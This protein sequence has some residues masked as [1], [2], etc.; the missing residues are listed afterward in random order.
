MFDE[1][2]VRWEDAELGV[3]LKKIGVSRH[4]VLGGY[5]HHLKP[6]ISIERRMEYAR[7]D[8]ESAA[9]LFQR[10]PSWRMRIRSGLHPLNY[11]RSGVLTAPPLRKA[12]QKYLKNQPEGKWAGLAS[13]LLTEREYLR[14]GREQLKRKT[15][16]EGESLE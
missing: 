7:N 16:S 13:S 6:P 4:F 10:Y 14:S 8:G 3:R 9:L 15:P 2:F 1:N 12:Y 5:V 11:F